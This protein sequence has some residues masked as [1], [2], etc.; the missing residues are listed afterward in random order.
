[1]STPKLIDVTPFGPLIVKV[2]YDNF[3]WKELKP[4]C[5]NL[6][7][8]SPSKS[9][10]D[11]DLE[12]GDA[13]SS[14]YNK[15]RAHTIKE[16]NNF[17]DWLRPIANHI[18]INEWG[19][20]NTFKF[21]VSNSWVNVHNKTGIT[22]EHHHSAVTIVAAA[23]LQLPENGGFIQFRDPMEY[24]KGF[25]PLHDPDNNVSW[26]TIE[27]KTGDVILF[28][29]WLRHRTQ[30]NNSNEERWVLTSNMIG[31]NNR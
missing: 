8:N 4:I 17:Y 11:T 20:S 13:R 19:M 22:T 3:D 2:H 18:C 28:P 31:F 14:V 9:V 15:T 12:L 24:Q 26:K 5:H 21:D 6:I 23:Y 1:M 30:P 25:S 10:K 29:G 16:F 7:K 27:A